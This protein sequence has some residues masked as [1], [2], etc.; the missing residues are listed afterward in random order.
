MIGVGAVKDTA[1]RPANTTMAAE[2]AAV[3]NFERTGV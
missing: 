1:W 2:V 3:I